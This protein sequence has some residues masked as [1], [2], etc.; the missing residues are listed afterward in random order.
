VKAFLKILLN[1]KIIVMKTSKLNTRKEQTNESSMNLSFKDALTL[2]EL[3]LVRGGNGDSPDSSDSD[4][5]SGSD[6]PEK[7]KG[8]DDDMQEDIFL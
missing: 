4:D 1:L 3:F 6:E 8:S 7:K 2:E 5:S